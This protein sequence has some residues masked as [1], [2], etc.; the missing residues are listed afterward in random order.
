MTLIDQSNIIFDRT[1]LPESYNILT[2]GGLY[3]DNRVK[4]VLLSGSRGP[5]GGYRV[6]SDIDISLVL[7]NNLLSNPIEKELE[8]RSILSITMEKWNSHIE[9]DTALLFDT[10]NCGF[11]CFLHYPQKND[12][13]L[14]DKDCFGIY[15]LQKGFYGFVPKI[16]IEVEKIFPIRLVWQR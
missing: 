3:I 4:A 6:D 8:L 14:N 16:G 12:C 15:K 9:L 13:K 5:S 7:D 10:K 11:S 1:E 2:S